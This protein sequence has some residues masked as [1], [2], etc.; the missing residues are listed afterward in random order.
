[1]TK[2]REQAVPEV[3]PAKAEDPVP[4]AEMAVRAPG[5]ET[6]EEVQEDREAVPET[7]RPAAAVR[8]PEWEEAAQ[9]PTRTARVAMEMFL[10]C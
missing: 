3:N 8:V 9:I 4:A 5:A 2:T 6:A 10:P 1:M 7:V